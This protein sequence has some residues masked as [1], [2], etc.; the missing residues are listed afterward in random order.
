MLFI[1]KS[2]LY[3]QITPTQLN[4]LI[5]DDDTLWEKEVPRTQENISSHLR[6]RYDVDKIFQDFKEYD[7]TTTFAIDNRIVWTE[8][9]YLETETYTADDLVV[10]QSKIYKC[11][12]AGSAPGNWTLSEWDLLA[13]NE[14]KYYC[15]AES[16]GNLPTDTSYWTAGDN[17]NQ[18]LLTHFIDVLLYNIYSRLNSVDIPIIRKERYDGNYTNTTGGAVRWLRD[19]RDGKMEPDLP[20]IEDNQDDQTGNVVIYEEAD[21]VVEKNT[22][23]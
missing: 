4:K 19:I 23:F 20:L 21:E 9:E 17:R 13:D 15:I 1:V 5:K 3:L 10:Y 22:A 18:D 11:K 2:D 6:A 16:T 7:D 14:S 12:A 8:D